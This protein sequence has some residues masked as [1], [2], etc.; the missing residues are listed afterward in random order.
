MLLVDVA[1]RLDVVGAELWCAEL[2]SDQLGAGIKDGSG[3]STRK[4]SG[5]SFPVVLGC[6][7]GYALNRWRCE[8][9]G[10]LCDQLTQARC[11]GV[12][13]ANI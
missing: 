3:Q 9:L 13:Q 4:L 7:H 6:L 11:I 5:E 12:A 8:S 2:K 10:Q 1:C